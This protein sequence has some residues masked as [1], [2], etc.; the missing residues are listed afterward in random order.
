MCEAKLL[1]NTPSTACFDKNPQSRER[2]ITLDLG[3]SSFALMKWVITLVDCPGHASLF[4]TVIG[5]GQLLDG[6]IL[7][8]DA[9]HGIQTQTAECLVLLEA[10]EIKTI[11]VLI[12]KTDLLQDRPEVLP[13]NIER[14]R[15]TIQ[16]NISCKSVTFLPVSA[17]EPNCR[18]QIISALEELFESKS[19]KNWPKDQA[20]LL[21]AIDHCFAV[22]GQGT[23]LTGIILRGNL[24]LND[25]IEIAMESL[26]STSIKRVKSI[27]VFR[28]TVSTASIVK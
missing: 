1:S 4:R 22:K 13:K 11:L 12:N 21:L 9:V 7:V 28:K 18:N 24:S 5:A 17:L 8:I 19:C 16:K 26:T 15:K 23:I 10:L 27:Q 14:V 2:G 6:V 25:E 20:S 3:I